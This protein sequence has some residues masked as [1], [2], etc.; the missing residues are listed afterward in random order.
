[1]AAQPLPLAAEK[2]RKEINALITKGTVFD[3]DEWGNK[4]YGGD[5]LA[6]LISRIKA[7]LNLDFKGWCLLIPISDEMTLC[8]WGLVKGGWFIQVKDQ[9]VLRPGATTLLLKPH[10]DIL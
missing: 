8:P 10:Q 2:I 6:R 9:P 1:M 4:I 5:E 3:E 7:T